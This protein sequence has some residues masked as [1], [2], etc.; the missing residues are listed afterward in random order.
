[1]AADNV[2]VLHDHTH[3]T[4]YEISDQPEYEPVLKGREL[5]RAWA[6]SNAHRI[7]SANW[8]EFSDRFE[9]NVDDNPVW[10]SLY[11]APTTPETPKRKK[12]EREAESY[13]QYV[14]FS[15]PFT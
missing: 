3:G 9:A 12:N 7:T 11:G 10:F 13:V 4:R 1:M 15:I 6:R 5:I 14:R 8:S 2:F